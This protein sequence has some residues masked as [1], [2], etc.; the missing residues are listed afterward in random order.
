MNVQN[1]PM[2]FL[3]DCWIWGANDSI[4]IGMF[5]IVVIDR[6]RQRGV[7]RT[8]ENVSYHTDVIVM[9]MAMKKMKLTA[10]QL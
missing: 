10:Q 1:P 7:E 5:R 6:L 9:G 3:V 4:E 2:K 8:Q